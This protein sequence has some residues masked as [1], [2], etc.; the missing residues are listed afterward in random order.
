ML[1]HIRDCAA[2]ICVNTAT[3]L[4]SIHAA[5]SDYVK[6][7]VVQCRVQSVGSFR[8]VGICIGHLHVWPIIMCV[9]VCLYGSLCV[10]CYL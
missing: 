5:S 1:K 9:C 2:V 4:I 7:A 10:K 3:T 8:A 6:K